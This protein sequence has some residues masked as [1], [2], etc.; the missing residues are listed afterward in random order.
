MHIAYKT[1]VY[2][3]AML[4]PFPRGKGQREPKQMQKPWSVRKTMGFLFRERS[5]F[6]AIRQRDTE[7][8]TQHS[9]LASAC[10]CIGAYSCTST[11][12]QTHTHTPLSLS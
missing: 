6:K 11:Y 9:F 2:P 8:G 5:H 3:G 7:E 12:M 4:L 1:D 10:I